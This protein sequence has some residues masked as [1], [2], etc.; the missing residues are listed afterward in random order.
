MVNMEQLAQTLDFALKLRFSRYFILK[1]SYD[2]FNKN[3]LF[4]ENINL[5]FSSR[6]RP[7]LFVVFDRK[8][9]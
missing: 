1:P 3:C 4:S 2:D 7:D 6:F 8:I 9:V 5:K